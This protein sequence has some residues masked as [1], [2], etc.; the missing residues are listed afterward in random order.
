MLVTT[1][2]WCSTTNVTQ[3]KPRQAMCCIS[4]TERNYDGL[5]QELEIPW[6]AEVKNKPTAECWEIFKAARVDAALSNHVPKTH[7]TLTEQR[8]DQ[9]GCHSRLSLTLTRNI[10]IG[11][12]LS[13]RNLRVT[14]KSTLK[15]GTKPRMRF[16]NKSWDSPSEGSVEKSQKVLEI[17]EKQ[18]QKINK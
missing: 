4:T 14:T 16:G 15:P 7:R 8:W 6:D 5:R 3:T 2:F 1:S 12:T 9:N 11:S 13:H 17:C 10:N 18:D